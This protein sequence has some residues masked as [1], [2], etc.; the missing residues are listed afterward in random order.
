MD[1][2]IPEI[3]RAN[4]LFYILFA[5]VLTFY[6]AHD[7]MSDYSEDYFIARNK[8]NSLK[9]ENTTALNKVKELTEGT[10]T[11]KDYLV[12]NKRKNKAYSELK[13]EIKENSFLGF[14]SIKFFVEKFFFI[15]LVF[16]YAVY[17][18]F[19]SLYNDYNNKGLR[20]IHGAVLSVC[21]FNFF[22]I[23]NQF[24]NLN[25]ITYILFTVFGAYSIVLGA[26]LISKRRR[27]YSD[28]LKDSMLKIAEKALVN[29]RPEKRDEMLEY[30]N[31]LSD[32][33]K[34]NV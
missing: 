7:F 1:K 6:F 29:S 22:W 4:L 26:Y 30:I 25:K 12:I 16:L 3:P 21:L 13:D 15:F 31:E 32:R 2:R 27:I 28:R 10:Q 19:R 24:Q 9:N 18:L 8:F 17:N 34:D 23:F 20:F 33:K 14:K 5:G 11:Y